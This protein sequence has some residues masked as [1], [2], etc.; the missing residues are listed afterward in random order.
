VALRTQ[1]ETFCS[2]Y[3]APGRLVGVRVNPD[4]PQIGARTV[5]VQCVLYESEP[6]SALRVA[7]SVAAAAELAS[8]DGLVGGWTLLFGDSSASQL[9][10]PTWQKKIRAVC[11]AANG[12]F[13]YEFFGENLGHGGG[14][15]RLAPLAST[16]LILFLNPDALLAADALSE[17]L[18]A[19]VGDV[20][21]ADARQLPLEHPKAYDADTGEESWASGACLL[22][23]RT[24]FDAIGGFD[25]STFFMYCDDVDYSWRTRLAGF[26]VVYAPAARV[27]HDKRLDSTG[28]YQPGDA[29]VYYSAE[30]AIMI[31]HKYSN[32]ARVRSLLGRY[33]RQSTEP[34]LRAV[35]E[36]ESRSKANALPAP[37]DPGHRV[38]SFIDDGYGHMRL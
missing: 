10:S 11:A 28:A 21:A 35:A 14:H 24:T 34:A 33:R 16:D 3:T 23:P 36:Y 13:G 25:S 4:T 15:N 8:R 9:L 20:G 30:A 22:T 32:P 31:A 7:R 18:S 17:L 27:Y 37:L 29:E 38:S 6:E 26:R 19:V 12:E 2:L 1:C 5:A